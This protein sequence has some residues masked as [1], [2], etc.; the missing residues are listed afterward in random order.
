MSNG[1][2]TPA[3]TFDPAGTL[4]KI[5]QIKKMQQERKLATVK[6][7]QAQQAAAKTQAFEAWRSGR[8]QRPAQ[9]Q[10]MQPQARA[11][12][13]IDPQAIQAQQEAMQEQQAAMRGQKK[14]AS[15]VGRIAQEYS[16]PKVDGAKINRIGQ[17]KRNDPDIRSMIKTTGF[18]DIDFGYDEEKKTAWE[19]YTKDWS[20]EELEKIAEQVPGGQA[21]AGLPAGKYTLEFDPISKTLRP[22]IKTVNAMGLLG[23]KNLTENEIIAQAMYGDKEA[24]KWMD[25]KIAFEERKTQAKYGK[26]SPE[27]IDLYADKVLAQPNYM[28]KFSARTPQRAQI[29]NRIQEKAAEKGLIVPDIELKNAQFNAAVKS[30]NKQKSR[31]DAD[32]KIAEEFYTDVRRLRPQVEV[33][34]TN[35]PALFNKSLRQIR[36]MAATPTLGQEAVFAQEVDAV[37]SQFL[38]MSRDA[39]ETIS[40][41]SVGA[42]QA[43]K[44]LLNIDNPAFVLTQ[45]FDRFVLSTQ[46]RIAA[47]ERVVGG[48][49]RQIYQGATFK[50]KVPLSTTQAKPGRTIKR[51]GHTRDGRK[52]IE[53]SDGSREYVQ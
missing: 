19:R 44:S 38:R 35:Y 51:T 41:L 48:I 22:S 4:L 7:K 42:Q 5:Q 50:K 23:D 3:D 40:E 14:L 53:Y 2:L 20:K 17:M 12:P 9:Q 34:R 43:A 33:I 37:M 10:P 24:I 32:K 30:Y 15:M 29:A 47:R 21:L 1:W 36:K 25:A 13:Q 45:Q 27:A 11:M 8:G 26:L 16:G 28:S 49:E 31:L 52:V 46:E 39:S 18:D 6:T